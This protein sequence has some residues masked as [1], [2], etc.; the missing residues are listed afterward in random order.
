MVEGI[1]GV[2][3][4]R[5]LGVG[6][7]GVVYS[8]LIN[9]ILP[10]GLKGVVAA[11]LLA[12]LMSTVSGALNSIATLFTLD[13]YRRWRPRASEK[14]LTS[15][16]RAVTFG[17]MVVAIAWSPQVAHFQSLFQGITAVICYI[18]PPI[19]TVFLWGVL[20]RR[21]SAAAAS[22]TLAVGSVLGL[23]VFLLDWFK[24]KTGWAVP[25]MMATFYLFVVCSG[26]LALVSLVRPHVHTE[27]SARLVWPRPADAVRGAWGPGLVDYRLA[28]LVLFLAMI[29]L[30]AVFG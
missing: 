16:G 14:R 24:A 29:G 28:A 17:G 21:A 19:T 1:D 20:W 4:G 12:A 23:V 25:P 10:A 26:V 22:A 3:E 15:V 30:Y 7:D 11:A 2:G 27:E 6:D 9:N 13:I 8:L 18:A 5:F